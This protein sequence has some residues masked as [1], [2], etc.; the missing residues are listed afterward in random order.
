MIRRKSKK[1]AVKRDRVPRIG[2]GRKTTIVN[3]ILKIL[4]AK[5]SARA[6]DSATRTAERERPYAA[7]VG[8]RGHEFAHDFNRVPSNQAIREQ[9]RTDVTPAGWPV[10]ERRHAGNFN[11]LP[12]RVK[13][14]ERA[15]NAGV[16]SDDDSL[17][18]PRC[19]G[20]GELKNKRGV[21]PIVATTQSAKQAAGILRRQIVH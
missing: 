5:G 17:I 20:M 10:R 3:S 8:P 15:R 14:R 2:R 21:R 4:E 6:F 9:G 7:F 12:S 1:G 19:L 18:P 13:E 16:N 11:L